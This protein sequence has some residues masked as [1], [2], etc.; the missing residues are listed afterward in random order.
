MDDDITLMTWWQYWYFGSLLVV[1][2][3]A[4]VVVGNKSKLFLS[5]SQPN[6]QAPYFLYHQTPWS[7]SWSQSWSYRQYK[8]LPNVINANNCAMC[9]IYFSF[10][11]LLQ[12]ERE[13]QKEVKLEQE[14]LLSQK[15]E[16]K[17]L[18]ILT[19]QK[20]KCSAAA[21][22]PT[23]PNHHL[24]HQFFYLSFHRTLKKLSWGQ[25][26]KSGEKVFCEKMVQNVPQSLSTHIGY[27]IHTILPAVKW[28]RRMYEQK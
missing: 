18:K 8:K 7:S 11:K 22:A 24:Q 14:D 27:S 23:K 4:V 19:S 15:K 13:H 3:V 2:S 10:N 5:P 21:A 25:T 28:Y 12:R 17:T 6:S 16:E 20:K 9:G 26:S 1:S